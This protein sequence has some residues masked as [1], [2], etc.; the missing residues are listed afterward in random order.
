[1][2]KKSRGKW[3]SIRVP[4]ELRDEIKFIAQKSR[5]TIW[6]VIEL[7]VFSKAERFGEAEKKRTGFVAPVACLESGE[8]E[9]KEPSP[10]SSAHT[11]LFGKKKKRTIDG[12]KRRHDLSYLEKHATK[13]DASV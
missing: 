12:Y 5:F 6:K 4:C 8:E 10:T 9:F 7:A 2:K 13:R 3:C 1:M 11:N